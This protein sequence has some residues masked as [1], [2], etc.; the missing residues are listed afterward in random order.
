MW[1]R[2]FETLQ[3]KEKM[4][5]TVFLCPHINRLG[6]YSVCSVCLPVCPQKTL[7]LVITFEWQVIELSYFICVLLL[8]RYFLWYQGQGHLSKCST[9]VTLFEKWLLRGTFIFHKHILFSIFSSA[10]LGEN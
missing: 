8:V 6:A 1:E 9:K 2:A 5:V 3:R 4:P 7:T 10:V